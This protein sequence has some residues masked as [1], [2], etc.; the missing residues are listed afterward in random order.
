MAFASPEGLDPLPQNVGFKLLL[1]LSSQKNPSKSEFGS[2]QFF[3][4]L[5]REIPDFSPLILLPR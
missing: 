1:L 2:E 5:Q 4:E 3:L